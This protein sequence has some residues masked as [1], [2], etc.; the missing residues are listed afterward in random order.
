[1]AKIKTSELI[2]QPLN[3]AVATCMNVEMDEQ[4]A[5]SG[6]TRM[7]W[8]AQR[9]AFN[10]QGNWAQGGPI[11]DR[12]RIQFRSEQNIQYRAFIGLYGADA[13]GPTHLIAA[14]RCFVASR[15]GDEVDIPEELL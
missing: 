3:W 11:I 7:G 5:P 2:G 8:A 13:T 4:N 15:I 10:P 14:M 9:A 6:S 1:M 12:E